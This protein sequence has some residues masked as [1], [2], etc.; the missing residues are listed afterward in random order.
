LSS[1]FP[2]A[3]T[4][5]GGFL[6]EIKST[7]KSRV[8]ERRRGLPDRAGRWRLLK[9]KADYVVANADMHRVETHLLSGSEQTYDEAYR[10]SR[11]LAPSGFIVYLGVRGEMKSLRHHTLI[12]SQHREK[13]FEEI[14]NKAISF[15]GLGD[16]IL[17]SPGA[18]SFDLF[19]NYIK[20]GES[21]NELME[22]L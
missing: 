19:E 3:P 20:R 6:K 11:T 13:N 8:R 2:T 5:R 17:F 14:F 15:A 1:S 18:P 7:G 10:A 4:Y 16:V 21:F 12:F 9:K 22:K